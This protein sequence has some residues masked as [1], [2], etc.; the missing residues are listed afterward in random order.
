MKLYLVQHGESAA[1]EVDPERPLTERGRLDVERMAGALAGAHVQVERIVHSGKLRAAQ[2][3]E[4]L[5]AAVAS[6]VEPA[7]SDQIDPLDD[8]AK[9]DWQ[10]TSAGADTMLVGHLPFMGKMVAQLVGV[11]SAQAPVAF[12]PGSV[13]CLESAESGG[14]Q[15]D[16]MLRPELL[17]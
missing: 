12:R 13:V 1:K 2:T 7:T 16:W 8:P 5:A 6:G 11:N 9:F 17:E 3:A 4:I 14:W 10:A 15:I